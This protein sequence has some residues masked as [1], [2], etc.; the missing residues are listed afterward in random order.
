MR[1]LKL[2][3]HFFNCLFLIKKLNFITYFDYFMGDVAAI[4]D[5]VRSS[6]SSGKFKL[7]QRM[8]PFMSFWS[9]VPILVLLSAR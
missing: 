4:I 3:F 8:D 7:A 9:T 1:V 6:L 5:F 2:N